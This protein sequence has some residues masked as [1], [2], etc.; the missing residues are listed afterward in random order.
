MSEQNVEAVR[1]GFHALRVGG[2]EALLP[3]FATD[4]VMHPF[5]GWPDDPVYRGYD[6]ARKLIAA[7]TDNF[8][9][10][11]VDV[12]EIRAAGTRVVA[13]TEMIGQIK[14]SGVPIRQPM[15]VVFSEI[16][17]NTAGEVHFFLTWLEALKAVGLKE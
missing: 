8:E 9:D 3:F 1:Q 12:R 10:W 7:W 16:H 17:E 11:G 13:L 15:G 4:V 6:G 5:P 14:G 2:V